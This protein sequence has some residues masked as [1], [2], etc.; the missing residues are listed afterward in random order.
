MIGSHYFEYPRSGRELCKWL[1]KS[2]TSAANIIS[3]VVKDPQRGLPLLLDCLKRRACKPERRTKSSGDTPFQAVT[4]GLAHLGHRDIASVLLA[5]SRRAHNRRSAIRS[6]AVLACG[7]AIDPC[8]EALEDKDQFVRMAVTTGI[9]WALNHGHASPRFLAAMFDALAR[10]AAGESSYRDLD[11]AR[12]L[13]EMDGPRAESILASARCI[14]I[15]NMNL[16]SALAALNDARARVEPGLL[17]TVIEHVSSLPDEYPHDYVHA[18]ALTALGHSDPIAAKERLRAALR[19]PSK[20]V[21]K[22]AVDGLLPVYGLR[23]PLDAFPDDAPR[24]AH[25]VSIVTEIMLSAV[26]SIFFNHGGLWWREVVAALDEI[27]ATQTSQIVR[28]AARLFEA[29]DPSLTK[30]QA[31]S[32]IRKHSE[33]SLDLLESRFGDDPDHLDVRIFEYMCRHADVFRA[34]P[35][36]NTEEVA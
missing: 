10:I 11:A 14:R 22:G 6:L 7:E 17:A 32:R 13:M 19:S 21:R 1:R 29:D 3:A 28:D 31:E 30:D 35:D 9:P 26:N 5:E 25:V 16:H 20:L 18:N 8:L 27:G 24:P 12:V 34:N 36:E 4:W 2:P 33:K 15:D 23:S